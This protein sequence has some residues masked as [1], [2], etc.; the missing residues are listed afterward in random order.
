MSP[1]QVESQFVERPRPKAAKRG[2]SLQLIP[3]GGLAS[4]F[5]GNGKKKQ[6]G[7]AMQNGKELKLVDVF[8]RIPSDI[9]KWRRAVS[10][11]GQLKWY[12]G[13]HLNNVVKRGFFCFRGHDSLRIQENVILKCIIR[14]RSSQIYNKCS[15][16]INKSWKIWWNYIASFLFKTFH[17]I[18]RVN[19]RLNNRSPTLDPSQDMLQFL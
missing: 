8:C 1:Q 10:R 14:F 18:S 17:E 11:G 13:L 12:D 2:G 5:H 3:P 6:S 16:W 15:S 9:L 19:V 4:S 7:I